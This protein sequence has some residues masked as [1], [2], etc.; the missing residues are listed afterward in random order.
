[1]KIVNTDDLV[2]VGETA[3]RRLVLSIVEDALSEVDS[4]RRIRNLIRVDGSMLHIGHRTW[5]LGSKR[6]VYMIGAG[7][8]C[9]AMAMAVDHALGEH[10]TRGIVVVKTAEPDDVYQRTDAYVGGH[11]LPDRAGHEATRRI[12]DLVDSSGPGDLFIGVVSGGSSALMSSP[13]PPITVEDEAMTTE[14]LLTSGLGIYEVNAVRRH[15]SHVNGGRLAERIAARGAELICLGISDAVGKPATR[16]IAAP[17]PSYTSTPFGPDTTTLEDARRAID[18]HALRDRLP[19][20]VLDYLDAAGPDQE[21]PK[22]FPQHTYFLINTLPDLAEAAV[23][24][25]RSRG[26]DAHLLTTFLEGESR[27][28]GTFL[29]SLAK[30]IR[31]NGRPFAPPCVIVS[32]GETTTRIHPRTAITGR[33]GPSQELALGFAIAGSEIDGACIFSMDSEGTD[34][35]S[36]AAGGITDSSTLSRAHRVGID[37]R[38]A[39]R[40]HASFE[41]LAAIG[42]AVITGNTGTNLCDLNVL[43]VPAVH[44]ESAR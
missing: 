31:S 40:G 34:G 39:L 11:P 23:R 37:L 10:L 3:S 24:S 38:T 15:I 42:D 7:K 28:A 5:D 21:T 14:V 25:S 32:A 6:H 30:E 22:A 41:A 33:G 44:E 2:G 27:D 43:Y 13:I 36:P 16:D 4:Y 35:T 20:S 8:A 18:A 29:A 17:D 19:Q 26:V 1:M 12:L 9:N